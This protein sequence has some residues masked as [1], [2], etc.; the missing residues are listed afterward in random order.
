[1]QQT[2]MEFNPVFSPLKMNIKLM[3]LKLVNVMKLI[4]PQSAF[5]Q[6]HEGKEKPR[7]QKKENKHVDI[8]QEI[9]N[10]SSIFFCDEERDRKAISKYI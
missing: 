7:P 2:K 8:L 1:M 10:K 9:S 3:R 6:T 5:I 4:V